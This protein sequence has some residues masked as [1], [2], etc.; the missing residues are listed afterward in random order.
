MEM[1]AVRSRQ[2]TRTFVVASLVALAAARGAGPARACDAVPAAAATSGT[3]V[4][5]QG[6][7]V[8]RDP[9]T[10]KLGVPPPDTAPSAAAPPGAAPPAAAR[11]AAPSSVVALPETWGT[12][13]AGGVKLDLQRRLD[14]PMRATIGADGTPHIEC[15]APVLDGAE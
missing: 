3:S 13:P 14:F 11:Q 2:A 15:T 1:E 6:M 8:H 4:Q 10:G 7:I 5:A 9:A 12:T